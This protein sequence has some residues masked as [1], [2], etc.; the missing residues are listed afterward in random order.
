M[1]AYEL[2]SE[3]IRH[4][5]KDQRWETF[6]PIQNA[7]IIKIM[8][9]DSNY[10]LASKT[11]SGKTEAAFLPILSKVDFNQFG[12]Q[13]LYIS[14][15]IALINDQV[16]RVENLCKYLD[17]N[18]TKWHGEANAS[19]KKKLLESPNGIVLI[20]PESLE[21]LFQNKPNN[22]RRMF[23]SLKFVVI[24][25]IHYYFGTDR[26]V[27]LKSLL[28]R[29]SKINVSKFRFIGLSAT[30]GDYSQAKY[31]LGKKNE[32]IVLL[33]KTP[34]SHEVRINYYPTEEKNSHEL[35]LELLKDLYKATCEKKA[36]VFANSRDCVEQAS[37]KL[38]NI[39]EKVGG[40]HNYFSH[41]SSVDQ[42]LREYAAFFAK[43]SYF[44]PFTICCT[45][46]LELGID[47]G[48]MDV[49][50]QI[51]APNEVSSMV[52]RMGRSGRMQNSKSKLLIYPIKELDLLQ[53]LACWK[54]YE[55]GKLEAPKVL[56]TPYD[57]LLYQMLS[58]VKERFEITPIE[59]IREM[60]N[61]PAFVN[62][63]TNSMKQIIQ[64]LVNKDMLE[65]MGGK[66]ILGLTANKYF[67]MGDFYSVFWDKTEFE[68]RY[69]GDVIGTISPSWN[70]HVGQQIYLAGGIWVIIEIDE[71]SMKISVDVS[72]E[73]EAPFFEGDRVYA[74]YEV[75]K[76]MLNILNDTELYSVL[77]DA[78]REALCHLKNEF[79]IYRRIG[80][81]RIPIII[82]EDHKTVT[83]FPFSGSKVLLTMRE[84][85]RLYNYR[86][87]KDR[88]RRNLVFYGDFNT[89]NKA[90][91]NIVAN[92]SNNK[93]IIVNDL[94]QYDDWNDVS[95]FCCFLPKELQ[96]R[97]VFD[98]CF[99][100]P[101]TMKEIKGMLDEDISSYT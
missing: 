50:V 91:K 15:L 61:N 95:K 38:L 44:E 62:C 3:P 36:L 28:F 99:D 12:V 39:S 7:A 2:L 55:E 63:D 59:L 40:H 23:S 78:G 98:K 11:A 97:L 45:S 20:T 101:T 4:Y 29:L 51:E 68:V 47:I 58:V 5:V 85:F 56:E 27:H 25:E 52:Q 10:I 33:D 8:A 82:D 53:S 90:L 16:E 46:T 21:A 83:V 88:K 66:L 19:L 86:C 32:A 100:L 67:P 14:P 79:S 34:K 70:L 9:T 69:F 49:V 31:F 64:E 80:S 75:E 84:L 65:I 35:T 94:M 60:R 57:I 92:D 81:S 72:T 48:N 18:V 89:F 37:V 43:H 76:E 17:V 74:S 41:H 6:T 93:D 42:R 96:V 26:G 77:D 71:L 24:D 30:I 73:G 13:V 87:I 1:T 22:V 54:L